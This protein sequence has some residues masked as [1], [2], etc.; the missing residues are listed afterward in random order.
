MD[1]NMS[2]SLKLSRTAMAATLMGTLLAFSGAAP[3]SA[4]GKV[5]FS[6]D[7]PEV[8]GSFV[9]G[10]VLETFDDYCV[11]PIAFGIVSG[12][13]ASFNGNFY[14]GASTTDSVPTTGGTASMM[15][16]VPMGG[17]ATFTLAS[18]ARYV[19]FHWEA[20]NRYDRVRL[21]SGNKLIADF[22]FETLM[23]ALNDTNFQSA[24]GL[25][26]YTVADYYGNPVS[27]QQGHE[28]YAYVHIFTSGGV[29]FD[30]VEISEDADSPGQ[31]EFDN[32]AVLFAGDGSINE[33]T[34]DDVVELQSVNVGSS[35][36]ELASTGAELPTA[37]LF[38][39][40][41]IVG[42]AVVL[43]RRAARI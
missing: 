24:D 28:P 35:K 1:H 19:G 10:A 4:A 43:R 23:D 29:T 8:Q 21:F 42:F 14:S 26:T 18:P 41:L 20:G 38:A 7:A 15:A 9:Q 12:Q 6:V 17:A 16:V 32:M 39:S 36:E 22:S 37:V 33:S 3:A 40:L 5:T 2:L 34:F 31:F 30:S 25:T 27:G 13:C 11:N